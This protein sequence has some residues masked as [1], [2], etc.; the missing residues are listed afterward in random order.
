MGN[1]M[2]RWHPDAGWLEIS[3]PPRSPTWRTGRT[4][5]TGSRPRSS[6][7]YRG[8]EVAAQAASGAV[9]YDISYD[10]ARGRWYVDASL[11]GRARP[12]ASLDE[13]RRIRSSRSM[14]TTATSPPPSSRRRQRPRRPRH[15]RPGP[16]GLPSTTRDGR[17]RA[18]ISS[19]IAAAKATAR[20]RS[21]SRT[22]TSPRPAPKDANAHGSR[23]PGAGAARDFRRTVA[24]IPTG[25]SATGWSRWRPR[26]PVGHRR[27]PR[28]HLP[29]GSRALAA[30]PAGAPPEGDRPPRGSAGDRATRARAPG[31]A[32]RDREP[33]RPGGGGT[34]SP[35]AAQDNPGDQGPHPGNPPPHEAPGSHPAPRPAGLTGTRRAARRP[36]T[37]RGRRP[38][39]TR[40]R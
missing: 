6:S 3:C 33:R 34:A 20:R 22:S 7:P 1:E 9:R 26:G 27:R 18:A 13:L 25:S 15:H 39:R 28:L 2:I 23:L 37:V 31:Q 4:A 32:P 21:S 12:R 29:L 30:A 38:A 11:E 10:P 19:L 16:A 24:G 35:G 14:S 8:D 36:K 5:G 40:S 17:L